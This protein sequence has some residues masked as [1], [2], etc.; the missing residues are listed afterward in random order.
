MGCFNK[1]GFY[2]NLPIKCGDDIVY[3]ICATFGKLTD[4]TYCNDMIEPIC[5]PIFGKYNDYG[6]ID[7]I[8]RD[9]NVCSIENEFNK[10]INGIIMAIEECQYFS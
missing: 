7:T 1:V 4:N 6:S 9:K 10:S 5:L 2:S 3:F 8:I